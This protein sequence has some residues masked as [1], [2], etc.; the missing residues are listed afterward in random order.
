MNPL[1]NPSYLLPPLLATG[2]SG[3]L[4]VLVVRRA[5]SNMAHRYFA[6]F[7]TA[8]GLWSFL[9]FL[10]RAS[11]D[12]QH[13]LRWEH[14]LVPVALAS[15]AAFYGFTR[16]YTRAT[17]GTTARTAMVAYVVC[18]GVLG[19]SGL[20]VERMERLSYGYAPIFTW[21]FY[22]VAVLAYGWIALGIYTLFQ[23]Y[24]RARVYEERNR[25][26][27]LVFGTALPVAGTVLDLFPSAY[28]ASILGNV[29]FGLVT[30]VAM[31][32]YHLLDIGLV[33]RK[34]LAYLVMS[35]LVAVP[36]VAVIMTAT[37]VVRSTAAAPIVSVVLLVGL[38]AFLQPLWSFA[39]TIVDR[40]FFR[41]RLDGF[42]ALVEFTR[43]AHS[44]SEQEHPG[45]EL[46]EII[47][48]A[49]RADGV[50]LLLQAEQGGFVTVAASGRAEVGQIVIPR[51]SPLSLWLDRER[52][53]LEH[54]RLDH[55]PR[56][57]PLAGAVRQSLQDAGVGLLVPLH[58][59]DR[60]S[61]I[62]V[63]GAKLADIPYSKEELALLSMVATQ[64]AVLLDNVRLYQ[65][66]TTQLEQ[67]RQRLEAFRTAASKLALQENHERAL[68]DLLDTARTLVEARH[69]GL[70]LRG[71]AGRLELWASTQ[72]ASPGAGGPDGQGVV[73]RN[74]AP[75]NGF[76]NVEPGELL[77]GG[78]S[79]PKGGGNG[80]QTLLRV[81]VFG[82]GGLS[83]T[84]F[85]EEKTAGGPFTVDDERILQL[86]AVLAQVLLEN[87]TL[88]TAVAQERAT[89]AA[90]Q[91][92]MLEGLTVVDAAGRIL[93]CN[94]AAAALLGDTAEHLRERAAAEVIGKGLAGFEPPEALASLVNVSRDTVEGP[95]KV[96]LRMV[97]PRPMDVVVTVF[98]ISAG[99][100]R[101][102]TGL[103]FRDI[104]AERVV[105]RRRD[106]FIS[107]ASHEL[108][109]PM[110][111]IMGFSELL[112]TRD[113]ITASQRQA[114]DHI[115]RDSQRLTTIVED[116]LNV[117]RIESGRLKVELS[118]FSLREV[119]RSVVAAVT[120][121]SDRH[122]FETHI[123][124]EVDRVVADRDKCTQVLT[125]LVTNA[126][127]YSPKGGLV[128]V[129]VRR[130]AEGTTVV[131]VKDQGIGI[132]VADRERLFTAFS[133]IK[134][135]E[136]E[137]IR[138]TG[139]GLYI[140]R[141]LVEF[142]GGE[143]SIDSAPGAGST[144]S[145]TL[146]SCQLP[147]VGDLAK[148]GQRDV[149]EKGAG[150]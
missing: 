131:S 41:G 60:L 112:L 120:L 94:D 122:R 142:M 148:A 100:G 117:S 80:R 135:P 147:A 75:M 65:A 26:L 105:E 40:V 46:V 9:V 127:K 8:V 4:C 15:P 37:Q 66:A 71:P 35:A 16:A 110:T 129:A 82:K 51:H 7:L 81:P 143:V 124:V 11:P 64:A 1:E 121:T 23:A 48:G 42:R 72:N 83:G 88:F 90:V 17:G 125:N 14:L 73:G 111:T 12:V 92:S 139:L 28:P 76:A 126:V 95:R 115:Y 67:G 31:R 93:Y 137:G 89:L 79:A 74:G 118:E 3:G 45:A 108:R 84:L 102:M 47:R 145:F 114:L 49:V 85:V 96:E 113:S 25:L 27:Y 38:A 58:L 134:R 128:Q 54:H 55:D 21:L 119:L 56:L 130:G 136:T 52:R 57:Q 150:R 86:F 146:P 97:G 132:S 63:L 29:A 123:P 116:L 98:P 30:V 61:G 39:Q 77:A 33:V 91:S 5:A 13:A 50:A 32:R 2:L 22:P 101:R 59:R 68:Q 103:L 20:L 141:N 70:M 43:R 62:L 34:G 69:A 109:T 107:V 18:A 99:A 106:E 53:P 19:A 36:Y 87:I 144:F 133:R 44:L 138:G 140:V 149:L 24:R 104:T 6:V 10:M 78:P